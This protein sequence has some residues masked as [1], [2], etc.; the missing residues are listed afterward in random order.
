MHDLPRNVMSTMCSFC[1]SLHTCNTSQLLE[2]PF[3]F[4]G[5]TS[6]R[7][8]FVSGR[9]SHSHVASFHAVCSM[10]DECRTQRL[11][12]RAGPANIPIKFT[13]NYK[14]VNYQ[15]FFYE[16]NTKNIFYALRNFSI[17]W[18]CSIPV[19]KCG[20]AQARECLQWTHTRFTHRAWVGAYLHL[21]LLFK[22]LLVCF[23]LKVFCAISSWDTLPYSLLF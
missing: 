9:K 10:R 13:L 5:K 15:P 7:C 22:V 12:R 3:W 8:W 21:L 23:V 16:D 19:T 14:E 2:L 11:R 18:P 17:M 20:R 4:V 1:A 6:F